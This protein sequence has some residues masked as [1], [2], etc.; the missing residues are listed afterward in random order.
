MLTCVQNL[1]VQP[2]TKEDISLFVTRFVTRLFWGTID[3]HSRKKKYYGSQWC[4]RTAL[5]PTFFRISSFV[6]SRTKK[7]IQ[8]WN[9][10]RVSKRWQNFYF[11]VSYPFKLET[12]IFVLHMW[13]LKS[14]TISALST[15]TNR[16][17]G[18]SAKCKVLFIFHGL[19]ES[20]M[21]LMKLHQ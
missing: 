10:L 15:F 8:V 6:F 5:F 2:N 17:E 18:K 11:W 19:D 20:R 13:I 21:T 16:S 12:Q 3:V 9:N 7:F 1:F 4:P 14:L